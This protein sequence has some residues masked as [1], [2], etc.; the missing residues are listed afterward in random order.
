MCSAYRLNKQG[1]S[2]QPYHTPFSI[3]NQSVVP[4][5]VLTV[6]SWPAYRFLR[7]QMVCY[8]HLSKRFP[9]FDPH[10][11]R[12]YHCWWNRGRWFPG[13]LLL[14]LWSSEI[15]EKFGNLISG[16]SALSKPSMDIWKFLVCIMLKPSMQDFKHDLPSMGDEY[17][18]QM[19]RIF[20]G[21]TLLGNWDEDWHFPVP[22]PWLDLPDLLTYWMQH[23]DGIIL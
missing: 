1:D 13:I 22:W 18:C 19:V 6:A 5:R 16:S 21:T 9:Q 20:F 8:S 23:L 11:Q 15:I 2:R 4:Y 17:N 10:S 7:R 12:L 14:S 3:L